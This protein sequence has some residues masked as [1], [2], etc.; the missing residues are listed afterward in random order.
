MEV[1]RH[2][3]PGLLEKAYH[4]T[5]TVELGL[6][7]IPHAAEVPI[8]IQYK[9][10]TLNTVYR[11]DF[12]CYG[13]VIVEIKALQALSER[14]TAQLLH[15]LKVTGHAVGLLINFGATSLEFRRYANTRPD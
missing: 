8:P 13:Q 5:S 3:G 12:V 2:L 7:S 4:E 14:E 9:R 15:Y 10:V 6:K 1:H 11:A